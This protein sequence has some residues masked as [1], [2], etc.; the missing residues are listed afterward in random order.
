MNLSFTRES[1]KID[2]NRQTLTEKE[3]VQA[4]QEIAKNTERPETI[5]FARES[6]ADF[7]CFQFWLHLFSWLQR[8]I[9]G[10]FDFL[11]LLLWI[12]I[13]TSLARTFLFFCFFLFVPHIRRKIIDAVTPWGSL[14]AWEE[15]CNSISSEKMLLEWKTKSWSHMFGANV[16]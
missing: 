3:L 6:S 13:P 5:L 8:L 16:L 9:S 11:L 4:G 1:K 10:C 12:I 7:L 14:S 15:N 2:S